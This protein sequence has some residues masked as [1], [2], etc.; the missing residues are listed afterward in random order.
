[1]G[2]RHPVCQLL[3]YEMS[4]NVCPPLQKHLKKFLKISVITVPMYVSKILDAWWAFNVC[5]FSFDAQRYA[6]VRT[7]TQTHM[8]TQTHTHTPT[9]TY[10]LARTHIRARAHTYTHTYTPPHTHAHTHQVF[11]DRQIRITDRLPFNVMHHDTLTHTHIT[12][13]HIHTH[14]HTHTH[15]HKRY[16]ATDK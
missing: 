4:I 14:T 12:H 5:P 2:L 13:T 16:A 1:M 3:L 8:H 7:H 10:T 11:G 15:T 9:R 6:Q